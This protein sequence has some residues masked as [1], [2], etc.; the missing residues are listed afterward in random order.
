MRLNFHASI[1]QRGAPIRAVGGFKKRR[2]FPRQQVIEDEA[3]VAHLPLMLEIT[4]G[5][6]RVSHGRSHN[7]GRAAGYSLLRRGTMRYSIEPS[8]SSSRARVVSFFSPG[9]ERS[10]GNSFRTRANLAATRTPR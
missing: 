3:P 1:S 8:V 10:R 4:A 5:N 9:A 2:H 7:H 6:R